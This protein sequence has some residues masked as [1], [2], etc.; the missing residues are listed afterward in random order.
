MELKAK[1]KAHWPEGLIL[2]VAALARLLLLSLK[3]PHFDE[4]VNGWFVDQMTHTGF[5]HYDPTNYHG[6]F[7]FYVLFLAQTLFGRHIWAL[8]LPLALI[9]L[10]TVWLAMRFERFIGRNAALWAAAAMAVSPGSVFYA[11]YAIHEDWLVF[12]LMLSAW[13]LMGLWQTGEK[14]DLWAVWIGAAGA[15]LTKETYVIHFAACIL[16]VPCVAIAGLLNGDPD[17]TRLPPQ[18][19]KPLDMGICA[20]VFLGSVLFFYSGAGMDIPGLQG[21]YTTF[22]AWAHTGHN[23]NGH[24]KP[25][26]YWLTLLGQY[27]WPSCFGLVAALAAILPR[28]PRW[29]WTVTA[30]LAVVWLAFCGALKV[31]AA[32][33]TYLWHT[34]GEADTNTALFTAWLTAPYLV[35]CAAILFAVMAAA[36]RVP[37]YMRALAIYG[38]G[39]LVAYSIIHYKTPWCII[40][41][42]WPFLLLFGCGVDLAQRKLGKPVAYFAGLVLFANGVDMAVLN[43]H[44]YTRAR[45]PYVYVQT[46]PAANDVINPIYKLAARN[47]AHYQ[48]SGHILMDSYHPLPWLLGDFPN[49]GYYDDNTLPPKMDADFLMVD[50]SRESDVESQLHEAY[51]TEVLTLRDAQAPSKV[52]F[53]AKTFAGIFPGRK[54]EFQPAPDTS[55]SPAPQST[56]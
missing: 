15:V 37:R 33:G 20:I 39:A 3:P 38:I 35:L 16:T 36:P 24:E 10:A 29:V 55:P 4:G 43:F 52:Y 44:N 28:S 11:R 6:P 41:L 8:R 48:L 32:H 46:F 17:Y 23:G 5:Y 21:L 45:E 31:M 34:W 14:K 30:A 40:S 47:P 49:I 27:E 56:P 18:K 13:G 54:P 9:S 2:L 53:N 19:W 51:Y 7:H 26:F 25:W 1:I 50:E 42:T 12:S 22:G